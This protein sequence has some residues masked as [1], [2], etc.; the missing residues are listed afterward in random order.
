MG[1]RYYG[2]RGRSTY[3][4]RKRYRKAR[5]MYSLSRRV[6]RLSK[7]VAGEKKHYGVLINAN[8]IYTGTT[9]NLGTISAGDTYE[10]REGNLI[11]V[12]RIRAKMSLKY[13]PSADATYTRVMVVVD[14]QQIADTVPAIS[15]VLTSVT[16][17]SLL[18]PTHLGR[19]SI[20][21]DKTFRTSQDYDIAKH[22]DVNIKCNVNMRFN[23]VNTGDIQRNGIYMMYFTD[24]LTYPPGF[25]ST[26]RLTFVDN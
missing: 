14:R 24:E 16:V 8:P 22:V 3:G 11:T 19:F 26:W 12:K 7:K 4:R 21:Y 6:T 18:N 15:D 1:K 23:G 25:D 17:N 9:V 20:L 2:R 10:Q 5:S 13:N